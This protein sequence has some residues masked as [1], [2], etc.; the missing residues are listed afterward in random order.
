MIFTNYTKH[1]VNCITEDKTV[2]V[3]LRLHN[4]NRDSLKNVDDGAYK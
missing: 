1:T 2:K 4:T 3:K